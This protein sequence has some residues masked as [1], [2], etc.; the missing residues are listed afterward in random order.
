MVVLLFLEKQ[1][2]RHIN[3]RTNRRVSFPGAF[4][5]LCEERHGRTKIKL[6]V[7]LL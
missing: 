4:K 1:T 3:G 2:D 6:F 7:T 5:V